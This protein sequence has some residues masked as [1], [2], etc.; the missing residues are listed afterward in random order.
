MGDNSNSES[1]MT[2]ES[3]NEHLLVRMTN[4]HVRRQLTN[5][6]RTMQNVNVRM[7]DVY[8]RLQNEMSES[9]M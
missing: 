2:N 8:Q 9:Q 6:N 4:S 7:E 5:D 1:R 3:C